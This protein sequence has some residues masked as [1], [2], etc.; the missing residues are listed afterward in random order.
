[1]SANRN[2]PHCQAIEALENRQMLSAVATPMRPARPAQIA[3]AYFDNRGQATFTVSVA[4]DTSTLSRKTAAF[5]TAG[6]DGVF[7]TVDDARMYTSVSYRKGRLTLSAATAVGQRY[8][9]KLNAAVIKDAGVSVEN[10][11]QRRSDRLQQAVWQAAD[12]GMD[13][14]ERLRYRTCTTNPRA[15]VSGAPAVFARARSIPPLLWRDWT[16]LLM[17]RLG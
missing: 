11:R 12:A 9:V 6:N 7:G 3:S 14:C 2:Y 5:Y 13:T 16:I 10:R 15:P 8:R 4:L 17:G 1:M